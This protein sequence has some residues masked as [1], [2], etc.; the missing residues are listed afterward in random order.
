MLGIMKL[1]KRFKVLIV[2]LVIINVTIA[3][4]IIV[5]VLMNRQRHHFEDVYINDDEELGRWNHALGGDGSRDKPYIIDDLVVDRYF[6]IGGTSKFVTVKNLTV[7]RGAV[8]LVGSNIA[9]DGLSVTSGD[10][11]GAL[12][13]RGRDIAISNAKLLGGQRGI[14]ME[15]ECVMLDRVEVLD[16]TYVCVDVQHGEDVLF[17]NCT[18]AGAQDGLFITEMADSIRLVHCNVTGNCQG[19][20]MGCPNGLIESC[21]LVGNYCPLRLESA[22]GG[23]RILGNNVN[24]S[25]VTLAWNCAEFL[26]PDVEIRGN[27]WGNATSGET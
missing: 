23:C 4:A 5:P 26:R 22:S 2:A 18:F 25:H 11:M 13:V 14:Y 16:S 21:N 7:T 17:T 1:D 15:G 9:V 6:Y 8:E 19:V 24:G 3:A 10:G 27:Y 20:W 12:I